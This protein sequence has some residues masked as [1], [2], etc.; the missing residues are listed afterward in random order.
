MLVDEFVTR[1]V[2]RT[3][4]EGRFLNQKCCF[5]RKRGEKGKHP[6]RVIYPIIDQFTR[7]RVSSWYFQTTFT[8]ESLCLFIAKR[9][10]RALNMRCEVIIFF[11]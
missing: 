11:K 2:L 5:A 1:V 3:H 8:W 10:L 6:L 9:V 7:S 4:P